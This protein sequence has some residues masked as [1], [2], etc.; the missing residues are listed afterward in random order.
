MGVGGWVG[1]TPIWPKYRSHPTTPGTRPKSC[2]LAEIGRSS[3]HRPPGA[4]PKGGGG[5]PRRPRVKKLCYVGCCSEPVEIESQAS[6]RTNIFRQLT[7]GQHCS[8]GPLCC[9]GQRM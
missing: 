5:N 8:A 1:G 6:S 9:P 3:F 4:A 2:V 7:A